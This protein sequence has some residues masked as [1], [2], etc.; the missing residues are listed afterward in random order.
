MLQA[1]LDHRQRLEEMV[2]EYAK[3]EERMVNKIVGMAPHSRHLK[4][5]PSAD[6]QIAVSPETGSSDQVNSQG[7]GE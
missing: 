7:E 6:A 2:K 3:E 1:E 4:P 5:A